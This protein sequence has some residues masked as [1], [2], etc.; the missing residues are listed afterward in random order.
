M[1]EL[2]SYDVMHKSHIVLNTWMCA[3]LFSSVAV[4]YSKWCGTNGLCV[5]KYRCGLGWVVVSGAK[6]CGDH[7]VRT[8]VSGELGGSSPHFSHKH[9]SLHPSLLYLYFLY[10]YLQIVGQVITTFL[11]Q[12]SITSSSVF[13]FVFSF[14]FLLYFHLY[15][16]RAG[17]VF[18][19]FLPQ[20]SI[21]SSS[22]QFLHSVLGLWL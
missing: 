17:R 13:V 11:P 16:Q 15:L 18:A 19:T 1:H 6:G 20:A 3:L 4:C 21:T 10:L 12:A 14:V 2:H 5:V 8:A 9:L 7:I 22:D